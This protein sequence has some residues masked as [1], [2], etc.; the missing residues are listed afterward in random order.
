MLRELVKGLKDKGYGEWTNGEVSIND[1]AE[2][3]AMQEKHWEEWEGYGWF[4]YEN[5]STIDDDCP[6]ELRE[7]HQWCIDKGEYFV[8][9]LGEW[10]EVYVIN[11]TAEWIVEKMLNELPQKGD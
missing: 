3:F 2:F 10:H 4:K 5:K 7:L 6:T 1:L 9:L 8:Y 11:E